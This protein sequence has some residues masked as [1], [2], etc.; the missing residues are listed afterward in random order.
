MALSNVDG[1]KN[2]AKIVNRKAE[3]NYTKIINSMN[4]ISE[5]GNNENILTNINDMS[6]KREKL[7]ASG[8]ISEGLISYTLLS[9]SI[10]EASNIYSKSQKSIEDIIGFYNTYKNFTDICVRLEE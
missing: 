4:T 8:S 5:L 2:N 6:N 10:E 3:A 7:L 9:K 1:F